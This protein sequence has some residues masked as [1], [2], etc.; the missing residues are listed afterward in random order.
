MK[1]RHYEEDGQVGKNINNI[2][3]TMIMHPKVDLRDNEEHALV[4]W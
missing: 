2:M 1:K 4:N 3:K